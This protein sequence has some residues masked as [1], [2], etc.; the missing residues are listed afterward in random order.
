MLNQMNHLRNIEM[1]ISYRGCA[2]FG[3]QIQPEVP[4][5]QKCV[6]NV[7]RS[8]LKQPDLKVFGASRTD[9]GVHAHDQRVSFTT[10][11]TI[12]LDGL[13]KTLNHRLP[14]DIRVRRLAEKP[15]DFSVRYGA[16]GKHYTYFWCDRGDVGP[17]LS[18]YVCPTRRKLNAD[19][20]HQVAQ[21]LVGTRSYRAFQASRD[22]RSSSE[23]TLFSAEVGRIGGLV[24]FNVLGHHF[25]YRMVRNM[26][27]SLAQVGAG[28]WSA[29]RWLS[30]FESGERAKMCVSA[31]AQGLHLFEIYY[32][33]TPLVFSKESARF[34][35]ILAQ[36]LCEED[37]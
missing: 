13:K 29:E 30:Y 5:V 37:Q 1:Q 23:T 7:L 22:H 19:A 32:G 20:M 17:F 6:Q 36:G 27:K 31:P 24:Y 16:K 14:G 34:S 25:L 2:Y 35:R 28:L 21:H 12:P 8:T 18:A 3:W 4:T 11:H 26:A 9:T 15:A 10:H 33:E